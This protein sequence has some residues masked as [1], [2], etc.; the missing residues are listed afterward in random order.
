MRHTYWKL[1]IHHRLL[2]PTPYQKK[3]PRSLHYVA[4][5]STTVIAAC[6]FSAAPPTTASLST[7]L[8]DRIERESKFLDLVESLFCKAYSRMYLICSCSCRD[9]ISSLWDSNF[10]L[11]QSLSFSDGHSFGPIRHVFVTWHLVEHGEVTY[12]KDSNDKVRKAFKVKS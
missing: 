7:T 8:F 5:T 4:A 11:P 6:V 3:Y 2:L 10:I 12:R 1:L 9:N